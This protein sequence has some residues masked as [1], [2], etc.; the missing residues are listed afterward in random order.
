MQGHA[1]DIKQILLG[2][3]DTVCQIS[4]NF[5][6]K[7]SLGGSLKTFYASPERNGS[8]RKVCME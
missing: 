3:I 4:V 1:G 5:N 6:Y 2:K 8:V 7:G